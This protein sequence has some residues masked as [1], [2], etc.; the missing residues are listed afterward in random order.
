MGGTQRAGGEDAC[1]M[2]LIVGR[3]MDIPGRLDQA[4]DVCGDRLDDLVAE[5]FANQ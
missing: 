4:L 2:A 1:D 5:P 3:R